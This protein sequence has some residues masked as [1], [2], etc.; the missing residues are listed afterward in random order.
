MSISRFE[1]Y[2]C[3]S[4]AATSCSIWGFEPGTLSSLYTPHPQNY[5][6]QTFL[7]TCVVVFFCAKSHKT[8]GF[9][10]YRHL[11]G[12]LKMA[13]NRQSGGSLN[14]GQPIVLLQISTTPAHCPWHYVL[15]RKVSIT[16]LYM[17][18]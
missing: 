6:L 16:E 9:S 7:N 8:P 10:V 5:H 13:L 15:N 2:L 3:Q 1:P 12:S 14:N 17:T 4:L 18:E 11:T